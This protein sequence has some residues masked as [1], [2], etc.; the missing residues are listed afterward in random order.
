MTDDLGTVL[1]HAHEIIDAASR[2]D[3]TTTHRSPV[4]RSLWQPAL[5]AGSRLI[6]EPTQQILEQGVGL[7]L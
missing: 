4:D 6:A 7:E 2:Q 3:P 5:A 1:E